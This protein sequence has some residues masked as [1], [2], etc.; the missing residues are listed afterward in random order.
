MKHS[1]QNA[2][3]NKN[4]AKTQLAIK[5]YTKTIKRKNSQQKHTVQLTNYNIKANIK[6]NSTQTTIKEKA[7]HCYNHYCCCFLH[8]PAANYQ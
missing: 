4:K 6:R 7:Q 8:F 5:Q 2:N 3:N 1:I